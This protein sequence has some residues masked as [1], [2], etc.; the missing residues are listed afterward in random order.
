MFIQSGMAAVQVNFP[1]KPAPTTTLASVYRNG[2]VALIR[3]LP[4][5]VPAKLPVAR[6]FARLFLLQ[7]ADYQHMAAQDCDR[8]QVLSQIIR[9]AIHAI[10]H[11]SMTPELN[12]TLTDQ[13]RAIWRGHSSRNRCITSA[14]RLAL[15]AL[16]TCPIADTLMMIEIDGKDGIAPCESHLHA[17]VGI[18]LANTGCQLLDVEVL[19]P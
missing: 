6:A 7:L 5:V 11:G 16:D 13:L 4:F 18:A 12:K 9:E 3:A 14:R 15:K 1:A 19:L 17:L 10:K 2:P 8:S